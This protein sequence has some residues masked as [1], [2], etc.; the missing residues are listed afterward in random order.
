MCFI[1]VIDFVNFFILIKGYF[2]VLIIF[3]LL[4]LIKFINCLILFIIKNCFLFFFLIIYLF[5]NFCKDRFF[6]IIGLW[7]IIVFIAVKFVSVFWIFL[8]WVEWLVFCSRN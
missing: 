5:I 2:E 3:K 8:Y 1:F 7:G 4:I 6:E